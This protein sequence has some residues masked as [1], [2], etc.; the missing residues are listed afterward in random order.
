MKL[1]WYHNDRCWIALKTVGLGPSETKIVKSHF[2][3]R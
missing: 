1:D 3:V 2:F